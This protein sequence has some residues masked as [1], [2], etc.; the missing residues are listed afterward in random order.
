VGNSIPC[1]DS[2]RLVT[3]NDFVGIPWVKGGYTISGADCWG[4]TILVLREVYDIVVNE[5]NGSKAFGEELTNIIN[6]ETHSN[7]WDKVDIPVPGDV[8]VMISKI[9]GKAG[10][11]GVFVGHGSVLHSPD[12]G[13]KMVSSIHSVRVLNRAF[14]RLE[15]YRYDSS[16]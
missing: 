3:Y 7:R 14:C 12:E 5:Y 13:G 11:M 6:D 2:Q 16:L 4:L 1:Q 15:Y 8:C 10:H 9:T